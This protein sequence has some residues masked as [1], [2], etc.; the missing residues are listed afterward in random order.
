MGFL[1]KL[2][3]GAKIVGEIA[4]EVSNGQ[5]L[6]ETPEQAP[7]YA[8]EKSFEEKLQAILQ[9]AEDLLACFADSRKMFSPVESSTL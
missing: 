8:P 5:K 3:K 7:A 6:A 1:D 9:K 4:S 2:L